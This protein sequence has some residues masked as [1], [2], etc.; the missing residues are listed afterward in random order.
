MRREYIAVLCAQLTTF[1]LGSHQARTPVA[2]QDVLRFVDPLIGSNNGG[3]VFAGASLPYGMA[4]AVADVDGQNTSGFSTDGS[5]VTGFSALHDAGTGGNPSLGNFPLFPQYCPEDVLDNCNFPNA[6]RAVHYLNDS[7][8]ARPGYFALALEN[9]IHAEMTTTEHAALFRF[10]FPPATAVNGSELSPLILVDLTDLW[11]SRQNASISIDGQ[12]G[13]IKGNGTFLPSFGAGSYVS[14]FC[15]DFAGAP[16]RDNGVWVNN[17]GGTEPKELYVTR[18]FNN[19]YLEAGG[20]ARFERPTNGSVSV[21]VGISYISTDRACENARREIPH[22]LEDFEDIRRR[23]ESAWR[24]KLS[25]ISIQS[26]DVSEDLQ[27]SF[28]SGVYRT[29]LD[30]QDLTSE[31][32]LWESDEPYFDSFYCIWDSFRAQHPFLTIVDPEAQSR[33]VRSLLDTYKHEG[34]L[35]DC[36]MSL[37]KGWTQGGSNADVVLTDAYVKN[38]TGIDWD[39]AYEAMVNDAENEPLEWSYEGRGGL[40]S[41]KRLNYIPYLDFDYLGFGTNSRS[42]S[43]T[44][45]YS[46]NDYC[47]STVAKALQKDDYTKYRSRAGNWQNL[48][49]ADQTSLING[50]DTGFVGFFQPKHLNGTWG[51]Q[52]PIACSALASWCSLTSNPS[53]TFESSVWEYQ[54]YVPHDM[55]ALIGLLGGPDTFVSRLDFFHT[56]G[57]AD[58]GNEPVFLT[59]YQY[60]YAGRPA[61]SARRAHSYIPS[62]FNTSNSGL[63]GNDD[64]GAMGAFA[65][66]SMMG[67]FPNPGQDVYLIIPPFFEAV[68]I[69]HPTTNKTATIRNVNFDNTYTNVYIQ[70]ATLNGNPYTKSWISH[71]F[72]T[73][74]MTLELTLGDTES[75]WGTHEEDLPPSL[76][77]SF[78]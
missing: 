9:G 44:L 16:I 30:P 55:A 4:K 48:Y 64:S 47:L 75:D 15:A 74:G 14:Y 77:K 20:F 35:P 19:F 25:P 61:L 18:G 40:Q 2:D 63:P 10:N 50:T 6:A 38:L 3:N 7:V 56:S 43:R 13:R 66:F 45:E 26:G 57:L 78:N 28:W 42:I 67:L 29:M 51:Y 37:C 52:D 31:N 73:Q 21:R 8:V 46:Y 24:E 12:T 27:T 22:P 23:A 53:E 17:R 32:P 62:L 5:N 1:A 11:K 65:V 54:F 59:V 70:S 58:M 69:T 71:D 34:W 60:H 36:R 33:M 39:L 68:H 72:F 76:S 49:K 41:W